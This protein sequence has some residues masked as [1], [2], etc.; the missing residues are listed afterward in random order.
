LPAV[1]EAKREILRRDLE[2]LRELPSAPRVVTEIWRVLGDEDASARTLSSVVERDPALSARILRLANSAYFGLPRPVKDVRTACVVLGFN[3][4]ESLAVGVTALE[5]LSRSVDSAFDLDAFWSHSVA[6]ALAAER[7]ARRL[8]IP[9]TGTAFCG[10]IVH[11]VGKLVLATLA[12]PRYRRVVAA[13]ETG[14]LAEREV[15][16]YGADHADVGGWLADRWRF[17]SELAEAVRGHH[18]PDGET[19]GRWAGLIHAADRLAASAGWPSPGNP[20]DSPR[21]ASAEL[22]SALG[23]PDD[24]LAAVAEALPA[25][26]ERIDTFLLAARAGS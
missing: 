16:E 23:I 12:P 26:S 3:T 4:I 1:P 10:G 18:A 11:D 25:D 2:R 7:L 8:G 24:V 9:E 6:T 13:T 19:G 14:S 21:P 17:P 5:A 22:S 15:S 20:A